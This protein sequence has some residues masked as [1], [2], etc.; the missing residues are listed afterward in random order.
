MSDWADEIAHDCINEC[1]EADVK[2]IA[3]ELRKAKRE[4]WV[5]ALDCA[6]LCLTIDDFR[7]TASDIVKRGC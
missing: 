3:A 6:I 1:R 4:G 7:D 5:E 2:M